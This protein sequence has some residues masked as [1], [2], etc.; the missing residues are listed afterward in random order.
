[1]Y[2][3]C[4]WHKASTT[5]EILK[6][7]GRPDAKYFYDAMKPVTVSEN[8]W[9]AFVQHRTSKEFEVITYLIFFH[10]IAKWNIDFIWLYFRS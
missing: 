6:Y 9:N 5:K 3:I 10:H 7:R 1:M 8:E 4:K 2:G